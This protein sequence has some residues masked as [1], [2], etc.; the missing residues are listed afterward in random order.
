L[1]HEWLA[2]RAILVV[3]NVDVNDLNFKI[4]QLLSGEL[5]SYKSIDT[6]YDTNET[7]NFPAEFLNS[8]DLPGMPPF[9]TESWNSYYYFVI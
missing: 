4:Q 9:T 7:V 6:V 3:K 2:E 8:L 5:G 1:N